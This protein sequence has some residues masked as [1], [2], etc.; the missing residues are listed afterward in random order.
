M[1][2]DPIVE[3]IH[4]IREKMWDECG[5][6]LDRLVASFRASEAEHPERIVSGEKLKQ[7]RR[8]AQHPTSSG[9]ID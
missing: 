3:E 6:D 8:E 5:G 2:N 4:R 1:K 7:Q 9:R